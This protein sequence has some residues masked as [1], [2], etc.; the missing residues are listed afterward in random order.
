MGILIACYYSSSNNGYSFM[1]RWVTQLNLLCYLSCRY[2]KLKE[3][4][5]P[6]AT[7][8]MVFLTLL[9]HLLLKS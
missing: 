5:Y 1:Y 3:F 9:I 7:S 2:F 6:K 8:Y 4:D